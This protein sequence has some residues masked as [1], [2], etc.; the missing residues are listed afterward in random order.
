[1]SN[2]PILRPWGNYKTVDSGKGYQIK[3]LTINPKSSLSLQYHDHRAEHWVVIS[4]EG[5]AV[6]KNTDSEISIK[7][8][9]HIG[10]QKRDIHRLINRSQKE[11]IIAEIQLG[12]VIS[13]EDIVRLEDEYGRV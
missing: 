13:E 5:F 7:I 1:M 11:L 9:S 4:G 2:N 8:G 10:I 6:H 12:K 3:I